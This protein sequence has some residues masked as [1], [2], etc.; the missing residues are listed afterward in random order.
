MVPLAIANYNPNRIYNNPAEQKLAQRRPSEII[1][2]QW[3]QRPGTIKIIP[4]EKA[5]HNTFHDM[6]SMH[7]Q[8]CIKG[9]LQ[10][11]RKL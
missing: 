5:L 1:I 2:F 11:P 6:Q 4:M 3:I 9:L 8:E 7:S 10:L